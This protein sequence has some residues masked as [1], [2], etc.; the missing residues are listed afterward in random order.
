MAGNFVQ[1]WSR[2]CDANK[3]LGV[4]GSKLT[5]SSESLRAQ[6]LKAYTQGAT[7]SKDLAAELDAEK[8]RK[9]PFSSIFGN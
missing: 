8:R 6:L 1:F 4:A 7:D 2:L 9:N 3:S 5:I